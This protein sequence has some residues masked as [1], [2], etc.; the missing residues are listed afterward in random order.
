MRVCFKENG[1]EKDISIYD[2]KEA[3]DISRTVI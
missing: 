3:V 1:K 2:K